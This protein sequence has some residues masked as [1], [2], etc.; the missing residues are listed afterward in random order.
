MAETGPLFSLY[1]M[2]VE[3]A[4][5]EDYWQRRLVTPH[6]TA[7]SDEVEALIAAA[8]GRK[9]IVPI[10]LVPEALFIDCASFGTYEIAV[11][12]EGDDALWNLYPGNSP[13]SGIDGEIFRGDVMTEFLCA[14]AD[15]ARARA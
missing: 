8:C 15:S 6:A 3:F 4:R 2:E 1:P 7:E 11:P 13:V 5:Y 14:D 9:I 10:E 12:Y